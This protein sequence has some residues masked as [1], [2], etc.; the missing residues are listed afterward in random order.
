MKAC[1]LSHQILLPFDRVGS[2]KRVTNFMSG[3]TR[4]LKGTTL[5]LEDELLSELIN[6]MTS[7]EMQNRDS[8]NTV[9]KLDP[10]VNNIAILGKPIHG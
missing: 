7:Y 5:F 9:H 6:Q 1:V 10:D 8:H 4:T 3:L 2:R